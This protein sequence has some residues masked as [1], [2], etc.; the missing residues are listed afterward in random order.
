MAVIR[1]LIPRIAENGV[2]K[3]TGASRGAGRG[4]AVERQ[5]GCIQHW[6]EDIFI[7]IPSVVISAFRACIV[8]GS[9]AEQSPRNE[10]IIGA[11]GDRRQQRV[12][13]ILETVVVVV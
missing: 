1:I 6:T 5:K 13:A 4:S 7:E 11:N 3:G 8:E 2:N 9:A 10:P 12:I